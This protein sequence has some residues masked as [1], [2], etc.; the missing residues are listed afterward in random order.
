MINYHRPL[1]LPANRDALIER[2]T[3]ESDGHLSVGGFAP[4]LG[5]AHCP[6]RAGPQLDPRPGLLTI[7]RLVQYARRDARQ[8]PDQYARRIGIAPGELEVTETGVMTPEPRVLYAISESLKISYQK[9]L[10]LAGHR[11]ERD[12]TLEREA[13]RFAA[14]SAPMDKLNSTEAQALHDLLRLLHE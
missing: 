3:A 6:P 9:L 2:A 11:Q 12:V 13:L 5:Q 1:R 10:T 8:T 7:A 14:F 4:H